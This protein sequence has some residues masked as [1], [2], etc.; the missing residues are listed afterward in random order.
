M[1]LNE[2]SGDASVKKLHGFARQQGISLYRAAQAMV[3]TDELTP[4][5]RNSLSGLL[6]TFSRWRALIDGIPHVELAEI[7]LDESGYTEMWQN[8]RAPDAPG[9]LEN[10]KELVRSMEEFEN[11]AGFLE[12]IALIMDVDIDQAEDK[13]NLMTLHSAKGLEFDTVF[14]PGW[15]EGL[16]PASALARRERPGGPRRGAPPCLCRRHPRP[17]A[18]QDFLRPEPAHPQS[19]AIGHA[20]ALSRRIAGDQCG[21]RGKPQRLWRL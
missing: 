20:V 1:S 10:L 3:E 4:K 17:Q 9:R 6:Q 15:E 18:V 19:L 13:V 5:T 12:H 11:L 21:D 16:F 14:L 2:V 8:D 7:I